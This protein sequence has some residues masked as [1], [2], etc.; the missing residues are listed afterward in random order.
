M[1][2][3]AT[4]T[5]ANAPDTSSAFY[6]HPAAYLADCEHVDTRG[7]RQSQRVSVKSEQAGR[8]RDGTRRCSIRTQCTRQDTRMRPTQDK[9]MTGP[10]T[11]LLTRIKQENDTRVVQ[12]GV[13]SINDAVGGRLSM[14]GEVL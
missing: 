11:Y 12:Q 3:R 9:H 5:G 10:M 13:R 14:R 7:A 4:E 6:M 8:R 2:K 1:A